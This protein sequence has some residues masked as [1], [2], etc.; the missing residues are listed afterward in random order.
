MSRQCAGS[1]RRVPAPTLP[2]LLIVAAAV[3]CLS[4]ALLALPAMGQGE[5]G[6]G[7]RSDSGTTAA[8]TGGTAGTGTG[9]RTGPRTTTGTGTITTAGGDDANE[10]VTTGAG[11]TGTGVGTG[12]GSAG[13]GTTAGAGTTTGDA[14]STTGTAGSTTGTGTGGANGASVS[15]STGGGRR[16]RLLEDVPASG[17]DGT[18]TTTTTAGA[19]LPGDVTAIRSCLP[20]N[21]LIVPGGGAAGAPPAEAPAPGMNLTADGASGGGA[22][23]GG[24][25]TIVM[26]ADFD[27]INAT[28][29]SYSQTDGILALSLAQG[30]VTNRII[31]LTIITAAKTSLRYVQNF[32]PG[33]I[34]VGPGFSPEDFSVAAT[35]I[36]GVLVTGLNTSRA[37]IT[38]TGTGTVALNGTFGGAD[39]VAG[40]T[41]KVFL[42]GR[43]SGNVTVA[44]DGIST[45]WIQGSEGTAISGTANGLAK[46][47]YTAGSCSVET[48]FKSIFGVSVFGDP[49]QRASAGSNPTYNPSWSCGQRVDGRSACPADTGAGGGGGGVGLGS[50]NGAGSASTS[51]PAGSVNTVSGQPGTVTTGTATTPGGQASAT[52]TVS[53]PSGSVSGTQTGAEGNPPVFSA[54]AFPPIPGIFNPILGGGSIDPDFTG[55]TTGDFSSA[56]SSAIST[57]GPAYA[58]SISVGGQPPITT[59]SVGGGG[60]GATLGSALGIPAT[61]SGLSV[62]SVACKAPKASRAI[63]PSTTPATA[64]PTTNATAPTNTTTGGTSP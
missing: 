37:Y 12:T 17:S 57:G 64:P 26:D 32:G 18:N 42:A 53:G 27:V 45:T 29:I 56:T 47:L 22:G 21:I 5:R 55:L 43:T 41:S 33:N 40:G 58:S 1:R 59:T 60:G 9:T 7:D 54:S 10:D 4:L 35:T 44:V 8:S 52:G 28:D 30:Y 20:Y 6:A 19:S 61:G 48:A 24:N 62:V 38:N 34:V 63:F 13:T 14:T 11:T 2:R 50:G 51:G 49:C 3:I 23:R 15:G 46:V 16:R 39:I 25:A 31:N 36:G